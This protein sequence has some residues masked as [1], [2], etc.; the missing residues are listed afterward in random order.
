MI[1]INPTLGYLVDKTRFRKW[2][3][4]ASVSL[5]T[6]ALK[7]NLSRTRSFLRVEIPG[8]ERKARRRCR[9]VRSDPKCEA[10]YCC[11]ISGIF[12]STTTKYGVSLVLLSILVSLFTIFCSQRTCT[13]DCHSHVWPKF[14][15][16]FKTMLYLNFG[17]QKS[18]SNFFSIIIH[19]SAIIICFKSQ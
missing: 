14:Y 3:Q 16:A 8:K 9:S 10:S 17:E 13:C 15:L 2:T 6:A 4:G 12:G 1:G 5:L 19:T 18:A 11:P 7:I